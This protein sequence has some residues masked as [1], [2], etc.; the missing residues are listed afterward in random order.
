MARNKAFDETTVLNKAL[1]IFQEKGYCAT[2]IDDLV[3]SIGINRA[4][5]YDTFGDKHQLFIESL[6]RYRNQQARFM[7]DLL[8]N[9]ASVKEAIQQILQGVLQGAISDKDKGCFVVNTAVEFAT[10][11]TAILQI[12]KNNL[13][14]IETALALAIEKGQA[15]GEIQ[16]NQPPEALAKFVLA[17]I[18]GMRVAEK[19]GY[20]KAYFEAIIGVV[21][22]VLFSPPTFQKGA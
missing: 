17:T 13:D 21:E 20:E 1:N 7:I 8:E 11:D 5:L 6:Q 12:V 14:T 22:S 2:S 16:S 10:R 3:K 4:S 19:A 18:N 9:T 15:T